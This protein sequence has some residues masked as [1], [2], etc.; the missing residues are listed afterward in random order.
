MKKT[1][2]ILSFFFILLNSYALAKIAIVDIQYLLQNSKKGVS[3]QKDFKNQTKKITTKFKKK[4]KELRE[5][6]LNISS[7]KNV[8]SEQDFNKEVSNFKKEV[9]KYNLERKKDSDDI[10]KKKNAEIVNLLKEINIILLNYSKENNLT[11][12]I[13]K[14]YII[15]SKSE[16][17][18]TENILK[19]LD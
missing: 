12:I 9:S 1:T 5:K 7:K 4:E 15:I 10:N 2:L 17:D 13:D 18:I 19:K 16:N 14:K 8:L 6:E 3:I 11:T